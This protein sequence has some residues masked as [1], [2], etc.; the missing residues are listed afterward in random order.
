[1]ARTLNA[2]FLNGQT[3]YLYCLPMYGQTQD[4]YISLS[5]GFTKKKN[6]IFLEPTVQQ[7]QFLQR[8]HAPDIKNAK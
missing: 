5:E 1:M 4:I 2:K 8:G 7:A 3:K 6:T